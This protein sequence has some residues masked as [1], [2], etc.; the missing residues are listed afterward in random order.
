MADA[1]EPDLLGPLAPHLGEGHRSTIGVLVAVLR[2][3]R[4]IESWLSSTLAA[5]GLDTSEFTALMALHLA[6][7]PHRLSAGEIS[8]ALVQTTGGTTKTI[9]RLE[10]RGMVKRVAD[11]GDGRRSLVEL[12]DDGIETVV[13]ALHLVLDAFD[14]EIGDLDEAQ[15]VELGLGLVRLSAELG[16]RLDRR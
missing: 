9:R 7:E 15:R 4:L 10:D 2:T 12:S 3:G 8:D 1:A 5:D 11:P 16:E 13:G 14:L 6:G